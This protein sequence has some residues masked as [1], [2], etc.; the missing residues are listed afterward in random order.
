MAFHF[1]WRI[2]HG[3]AGR[4]A[5]GGVMKV[6]L[7]VLLGISLWGVG[8]SIVQAQG[9]VNLVMSEVPYSGDVKKFCERGYPK[10]NWMPVVPQAGTWTIIYPKKSVNFRYIP[11]YVQRCRSGGMVP[12]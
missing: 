1:T 2:F 11:S 3:L 12:S 4:P 10:H 7:A 6:L 9:H 8:G 5:K